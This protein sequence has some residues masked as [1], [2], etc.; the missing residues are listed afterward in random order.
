M[1][2]LAIGILYMSLI[3]SS[4][5]LQA[6]DDADKVE[7]DPSVS[8]VQLPRP[9]LFN[10]AGPTRQRIVE[11]KVQLLVRGEE[12]NSVLQKHIPLVEDAI[13]STFSAAE[14]SRL[15]TK[16]GKDELRQKALL[17]VQNA[18]RPIAGNKVIE[19]ILFTGFVMQ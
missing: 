8:Y 2:N 9:F 5:S 14:F 3:F 12:N 7:N 10:L 11:I 4:F 16:S 19:K 18:L 1:P 13:L 6:E 15:S 17:N